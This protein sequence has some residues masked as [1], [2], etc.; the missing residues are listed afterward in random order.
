MTTVRIPLVGSPTNRGLDLEKDQRFVNCFPEIVE[1]NAADSKRIYVTKRDGT[2]RISQPSGAAGEG[3]GIFSWNNKVFVVI[4]TGLYV[5][6][7]A[8]LTTWSN[9]KTLTTSSGAVG[10]TVFSAANEYLVL[11]DGTKGYYVSTTNVVT[12]ITDAQFPTPHLPFPVFMDS[13]LFVQKTTG[14]IFNCDVGDI[15]AWSATSY[16]KPESYPDGTVALARQNNLIASLGIDSVE[17][18]YDAA[19]PTPGSPLGRNL[20]AILQYGC[21]SG[22]TVAQQEGLL[23]FVAR[24]NTSGFFVSAIEGTKD[25]NISTEAINRLLEGEGDYIVDTWAF[26]V[27]HKGHLLYVLNLP[28]QGRTLV[29]DLQTKYW[30]EWEW[31]DGA[32]DSVFP[33]ASSTEHNFIQHMV[34][35]SNGYIYK[36]SPY[37]YKDQELMKVLIQT[38]R[39]DGDT[40]KVKFMHRLEVI[41]DYQTTSNNLSIY[42]S[43]DDYKTWTS[44]RTVDLIKRAYIYRCGSFRRRAIKLYHNA[45]V[46]LRLEAI[47]A[48]VDGGTH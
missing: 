19:N 27:R 41:G 31:Y 16:I 23:I 34:H 4:G 20:Q 30:H 40:T 32:T 22:T 11:L 12:E 29:F 17:F 13:Y 47:E 14:E 44:P 2:T 45:D 5:S 36:S 15:T 33:M 42:W 43:D 1:N 21:A 24:S 28:Y 7:N 3:R 48:E 10:F 25:T 6:T 9:I 18:F 46:A 38:S 26:L 8:G 39:F 37:V 35:I